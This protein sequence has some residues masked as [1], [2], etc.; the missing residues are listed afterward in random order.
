MDFLITVKNLLGLSAMRFSF[1]F[2]IIFLLSCE[3]KLPSE[4]KILDHRT[5]FDIFNFFD[6]PY[7]LFYPQQ[8]FTIDITTEKRSDSLIFIM[9]EHQYFNSINVSEH[10]IRYTMDDFI[11]LPRLI[12]MGVELEY[13]ISNSM[14]AHFTNDIEGILLEYQFEGDN[15]WT[16][17]N[18]EELH[19]LVGSILPIRFRLSIYAYSGIPEFDRNR[20]YENTATLIITKLR[21]FGRR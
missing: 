2:G 14:E 5:R 19:T 6:K 15:Q 11:E 13:S 18:E 21:I 4:N 3:S 16:F 9:K 8:D 1:L 10:I 7:T 12:D 17:I 20:S